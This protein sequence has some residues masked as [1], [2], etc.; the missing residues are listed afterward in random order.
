MSIRNE[1]IRNE[2]LKRK[3]SESFLNLRNEGLG[4]DVADSS[5]NKKASFI[6]RHYNFVSQGGE[7]GV[8]GRYATRPDGIEKHC[9]FHHLSSKSLNT[10]C[11]SKFGFKINET[12]CVFQYSRSKSLKNHCVFQHLSSKSLKHIVFFNIWARNHWKTLCFSTFELEI[13]EKHYVF[14]IFELEIMAPAARYALD[15]VLRMRLQEI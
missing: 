7:G 4:Q 5:L 1:L 3:S 13:I 2:G 12:H 8:K 10:L 11:F 14:T 6:R 15:T 9:V